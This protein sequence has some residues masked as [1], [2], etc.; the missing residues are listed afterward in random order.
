VVAVFADVIADLMAGSGQ[1]LFN[2]AVLGI[3]VAMLGWHN[4]WMAR[5]GREHVAEMKAVGRA[6]DAGERPPHALAIVIGAAVLREGSEVVLFLAGIAAAG[7]D[8][9][10]ANLLLGGAGGLLLGATAA[11]LLYKGLLRIPARHLFAV[12]TW[13]IT[14]LAAGMGAQAVTYLAQAGIVN[15][16]AAELWDSSA[17]LADSSLLG[18]ILH[19]L[20][21]YIDRPNL[22]QVGTYLAVVASI[23]LLTN[24]AKR[25]AARA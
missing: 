12:M 20:V 25:G 7:Q 11:F 21:G 8:G 13:L 9:G 19:V 16:G 1:E 17:I 14:L 24:M 4:A 22:L 3:A 6:V 2:A 23:M 15:V 5:H 10:I 18:K